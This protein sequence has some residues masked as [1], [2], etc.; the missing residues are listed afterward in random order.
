M[1]FKHLRL[2]EFLFP[3]KKRYSYKVLHGE[4]SIVMHRGTAFLLEVVP[5]GKT[6]PWGDIY[7][8]ALGNY[9]LLEATLR[10]KIV[11]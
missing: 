5:A 7:Y 6:V 8:D 3:K 11:P 4:I 9:F 2:L 10:M 1:G